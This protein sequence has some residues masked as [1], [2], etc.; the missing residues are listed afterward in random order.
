MSTIIATTLGNGS[1]SV[2]VDTVV[3]G[4]AKVWASLNGSGTIA[5][6]DS[7]NTSSAVDNGAGDYTFNFT[8]A[9]A[10]FDYEANCGN[11]YSIVG[12][13]ALATIAFWTST[14][15]ASAHRQV[16]YSGTFA[17]PTDNPRASLSIHG[18][19]A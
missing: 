3:E 6:R 4:S 10:A 7:F 9:L 15:S 14:S 2:P 18:D 16:S 5:L 1:K 19:A 17:T 12:G 13:S 8:A 11:G